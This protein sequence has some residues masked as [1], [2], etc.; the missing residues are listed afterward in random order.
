MTDVKPL[1]LGIIGCGRAAES[2]HLPALQ[3][4][5]EIEVLA[6]ADKHPDCLNKVANRFRIEQRFT[7]YRQ[8]LEIP[9]IEAVAVCAPAQFHVEIALAVLETDK[10]L[11]VE[12]PLAITL[13]ECDRLIA[14]SKQT[15]RKV[16]VGFNLRHHRLIEETRHLLEQKQLGE[17]EAIRSNWTSAIRYHGSMPEWRNQRGLGGGAFFE[18]A[19]HHFDLWRYLLHSEIEEIFAFSRSGE[20]HDETVTVCA[21]LA[22]RVIATAI[23]SERTSDNNEL[24]I[25]GREGRLCIS[26]FRFDGLDF[27]SMT[28]RPGGIAGR[29]HQFK[30]LLRELPKGIAIMRRGGDFLLSYQNEWR[31]FFDV[32]RHDKPVKS[33]LE[34]GRRAV[35]II[36][37]ASESA[38]LGKPVKIASVSSQSRF[39]IKQA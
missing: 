1:R 25:Y 7:D 38:S 22:N 20:S 27:Y 26:L 21:R 32:I 9:G 23:F 30:N 15:T 39:D 14:R 17:I 29:L 12:K 8:L 31:H 33:S 34:D 5:P 18:I 24:E 11:F 4:L 6:L 19:V 2:L 10:H 28:N 35:Q 13:Q 16:L 37:A 36:L 3:Q